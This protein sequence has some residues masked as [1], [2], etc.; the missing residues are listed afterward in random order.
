MK[1]AA[2]A[3][4]PKLAVAE[5]ATVVEALLDDA[6]DDVRHAALAAVKAWPTDELLQRVKS[7]V[8]DLS[9]HAPESWIRAQ[10]VEVARAKGVDLT[11]VAAGPLGRLSSG[12]RRLM[13]A[14]GAG[15]RRLVRAIRRTGR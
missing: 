1:L 5:A 10:A 2:A 11:A 3:A 4:A 8:A 6:A 13:G 9:R 7:R 14:L 12:A 15:P